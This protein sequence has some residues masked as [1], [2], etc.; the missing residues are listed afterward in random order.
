V[1]SESRASSTST[2]RGSV[3]Q[4]QVKR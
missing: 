2:D 3:G 1:R 4:E